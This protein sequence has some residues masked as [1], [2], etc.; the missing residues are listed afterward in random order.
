M[1][2]ESW[3]S[4]LTVALNKKIIQAAEKTLENVSY[5]TL[6]YTNRYHLSAFDFV[7]KYPMTQFMTDEK[8][9]YLTGDGCVT[10][11]VEFNV[12]LVGFGDTTREI[13][14]D[15]LV[16]KTNSS[17]PLKPCFNTER[18]GQNSARQRKKRRM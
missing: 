4:G 7:T 14:Q 13:L 16:E 2:D 3:R 6:K 12:I 8:S 10:K 9:A 18:S 17:A 1:W 5:G 15:S 11:D